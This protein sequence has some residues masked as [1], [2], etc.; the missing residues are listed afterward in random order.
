MPYTIYQTTAE[1][2]IGATD[3]VIQKGDGANSQTVADFLA[4]S[5]VNAEN[6]ANMAVE[7]NL[8]SV[9]P[10]SGD[11][12]P[13]FP[14]ATYLVTSNPLQKAAILR[15][16]LEEYE[17]YKT[18]KYRLKITNSSMD[19]A[20]QI[21]AVF[22][23][24]AEKT[25]I[26]HTF[27]SL[28]TFTNSITSEG[29]GKY[30]PIEGSNYDFIQIVETV[31]QNRQEAEMKIRARLGEE[32]C[33][34]I[35]TN[36]V[37]NP[38]VTAFQRANDVGNDPRSPILQAGNAI[39]SFLVQVGNHF[40]VNLAGANGINAKID[41]ITHA[42]HLTIKH[43]NICKYLGHVRNACDHGVDLDIGQAWTISE[44]TGLEYVHISLTAIRSIYDCIQGNF[45]I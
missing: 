19:A 16:V 15:F 20:N 10:A 26:N 24:A 21:K 3:A 1:E 14:Y 37:F 30:L 38:I 7:L 42:G 45:I 18:F 11:Y 27:I 8:I 43:K 32:I 22:A 13:N 25:E 29:A 36:D 28:G 34:W 40:G 39:E 9:D 41:R 4:T 5:L 2:I 33:A 44:E 12:L 31:V 23:L 6:A 35:D 17:P